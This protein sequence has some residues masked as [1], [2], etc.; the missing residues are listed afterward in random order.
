VSRAVLAA[1]LLA[2]AGCGPQPPAVSPDTGAADTA[3][4]F[5]EGLVRHDS[6]AA[7]DALDAESRARVPFEQ[8]AKLAE[9]HAK[10]VG[11]PA[12]RVH[13]ARVEEQ[14]DDATARVELAGK[15][16]GHGRRFKDAVTLR[17]RDGR[18]GVVLA[19]N[20]GRPAR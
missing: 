20:F 12:E 18:W 6:R 9:G 3:R 14:G 10:M 13:V 16:A 4:A 7:Y 5:F 15:T 11:F 8:F 2:L 17:R 1:A 19:E